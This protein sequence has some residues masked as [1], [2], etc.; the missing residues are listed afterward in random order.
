M[1]AVG[2]RDGDVV[3]E[4][5]GDRL[6]HPVECTERRVAGRRVGHQHADA[7]DV[8]DLRERV[9][10]LSHLLVDRVDRLFASRHDGGDSGLGKTVAD[11][12]QQAVHHLASIAARC[13]DRVGENSE[14]HRIEMLERE[15]L[16][17]EVK[18]VEAEPI[19]DRRVDLERLARD[20]PPMRWRHRVERAHV[21][22]A[23]GELDQDDADVLRH[24]EEHLAEA[25][26][27]RILERGELDLVELG[28]AVDHVGHRLAERSLD[29]RLRDGGIF[30]HVV[31]QRGGEPCA[32][33]L[34]CD[35]MLAT[36]SGCVMYGSPDLRN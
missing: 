7:V 31:K 10:L 27:L 30:H 17:L 25:L 20:P 19:G 26:G 15:V 35:R 2:L 23:I 18:R 33:S 12:V 22:E 13:L 3:L 14:A 9:V 6:V 4:L 16:Q 21:V 11:D 34:H 32:S 1:V 29:L 24:R 8:E 28:H 36:A 5:A